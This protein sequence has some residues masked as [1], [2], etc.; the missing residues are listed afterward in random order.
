MVTSPGPSCA[1]IAADCCWRKF[2]NVSDRNT[3]S[4]QRLQLWEPGKVHDFVGRIM[5]TAA[6]R[7]T[8][9]RRIKPCR[10]RPKNSVVKEPV[11]S[12]PDEH[13]RS[14]EETTKTQT[15]G[16]TPQNQMMRKKRSLP[17]PA[18]RLQSSSAQT[19][20]RCARA[21]LGA[22]GSLLYQH[23]LELEVLFEDHGVRSGTVTD[24]L[25]LERV[26]HEQRALAEPPPSAQQL[27]NKQRGFSFYPISQSP[28]HSQPTPVDVHSRSST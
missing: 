5:G 8:N 7:T 19:F 13:P 14:M 3:E 20:D 1:E 11:S 2:P 21:P 24:V 22:T 28:S 27:T 23:A 18:N 6:H 15:Q 12:Q 25:A 17:S 16:Q 26:V 4:K 9:Q 10:R